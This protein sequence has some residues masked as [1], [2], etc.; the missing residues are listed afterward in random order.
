MFIKSTVLMGSV[1]ILGMGISLALNKLVAV[2][3]GP[4]AI[5]IHGV[6]VRF[7]QI[8]IQVS[9][10]SLPLSI[11]KYISQYASEDRLDKARFAFRLSLVIVV[12]LSAI[13]LVFSIVASN[14]IIVWLFGGNKGADYLVLYL[15]LAG[16]VLFTNLSSLYNGAVQGLLEQKRL[17]I[18][19]AATAIL[20]L[21]ATTGLI[22]KWG[23]R[24][25]FAGLLLA[26]IIGWIAA[27]WA[28]W[29][30]KLYSQSTDD[31]VTTL[32]RREIKQSLFEFSSANFLLSFFNPLSFFVVRII[33]LQSLDISGVGFYVAALQVDLV[34][35]LLL[36]AGTYYYFPRMN[37]VMPDNERVF[38][39]NTYLRFVVLILWVPFSA[40]IL[41]PEIFVVFLNSDA[42]LPVAQVLFWFVFA[43]LTMGIA[44]AFGSA[45]I[46]L[47]K[48]R[49]H[50]MAQII[51]FLILVSLSYWLVPLLGLAGMGIATLV[52]NSYFLIVYYV[53]LGRIIPLTINK[54]VKISVVSVCLGMS[55]LAVVTR[56]DPGFV[57]R[58]VL[59]LATC[60]W[61]WLL[62]NAQ[63][64]V[65]LFHAMVC[66]PARFIR[67]RFF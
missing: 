48:L 20:V 34:Q 41:F 32:E 52:C 59:L 1:G 66:A 36:R 37:E 29:G 23:L 44:G 30:S 10:L 53:Y 6:L 62:L 3:L 67:V 17:A 54:Q 8:L 65:S 60:G 50:L 16:T 51:Y 61:G 58:G 18:S 27:A 39:I 56:L 45:V 43:G 38:L 49:F 64:R 15:L 22:Y 55:A 31:A 9:S 28:L 21:G 46:G 40:L 11:S 57:V 13:A 47:T 4:P 63:E 2:F 24:G 33:I 42:F 12:L 14:H 7:F 19:S 25:Y 26:S 35:Q 5:G